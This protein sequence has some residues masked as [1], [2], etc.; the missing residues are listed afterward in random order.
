MEKNHINIDKYIKDGKYGITTGTTAAAAAAAALKSIKQDIK[1]VN[2]KTPLGV[3]KIDVCSVKKINDTQG[4]ASVI[5]RSYHD[6]DVTRNL[7]IF[8]DVKV[9]KE[10]GIKIKG[11]KGVGLVTK[12]GLQVPVGQP[13]INPV[14][15]QMIK[16]NLM[17]LLPKN[18]GAEVIISIPE[19]EE[20]AKKTLNPRLGIE[21]GI[22]ILGT[23]GIARSMNLESYKKSFKCQLDV[24][25]AQGYEE[26]VFVPGNIGQNIAQEIL[27]YKNDQIIQMGNFPGYMLEEASQMN[28]RKIILLGHAGKL[29]KLAAGIFNTEHRM[30]DGRREVIAAHAALIGARKGVV[31]NIFQANTTEE[32]MDIL[33]EEKILKETFNSI[34]HAIKERSSEKYPGMLDVVIVKMDGSVLNSNHQVKFKD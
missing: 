10:K 6:P 33:E 8:A 13:A 19:G 34:A 22:S 28:I 4:R 30:A 20:L 7:E 27:F 16:D 21:G 25:L 17:N 14:P 31:S 11:G 29:I 23:T 5:K 12:P 32:M 24:A 26:L 1:Y 18:R 3:L 15:Q 2:L 9:V